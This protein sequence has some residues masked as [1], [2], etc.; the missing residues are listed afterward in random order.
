MPQCYLPP[1]RDDIPALKLIIRS[2]Y[3]SQ[4]TTTISDNL[5]S[6]FLLTVLLSVCLSQSLQVNRT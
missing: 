3:L 2:T 4:F 5:T 6:I 1:G